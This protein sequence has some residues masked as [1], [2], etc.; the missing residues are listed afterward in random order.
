MMIKFD[1]TGE[2]RKEL[3]A[4]ISEAVG[5][6]AVYQKAPTFA[7]VVGDYTI[8]KGGNLHFDE[9]VGQDDIRSLFAKLAERGFASIDIFDEDIVGIDDDKFAIDMPLDGF[10][11]TAL[12]NLE[13]LV[14]AKAWILRKMVGADDLP[15]ERGEDYLRFPW[16]Q[17]D[18]SD[19]EVRAYSQLIAGL[20]ETA[21]RKQRIVATERQLDEGDNEKFK[22]RCF[23][24]SIG[25]IGPEYAQARKVLL[26]SMSGS[27]SHKSGNWKVSKVAEKEY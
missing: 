10:T 3:V 26:A 19:D 11:A 16:L 9:R 27:G 23:L 7:Y 14:A 2:R 21:K 20:C 6:E 13:R 25:F 1:V 15:I 18:A 24:L 8:D 12:G 4:A 17:N 5:S 22:A